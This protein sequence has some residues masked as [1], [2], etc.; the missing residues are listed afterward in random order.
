MDL[1]KL[2][3][4]VVDDD[5]DIREHLLSEF[6][7]LNHIVNSASNFH[8]AK[9]WIQEFGS[10]QNLF[11]IDLQLPDGDGF[12][13]IN[14]IQEVNKDAPI[15]IMTGMINNKILNKAIKHNCYDLIE[16]PFSIK[17]D[18]IPIA[19]KCLNNLFLRKENEYLN[20]QILH[21]SKLAALGELSATIV[22]DVRGPLTM[23]Q[24][25]CEDIKDD[26]KKSNHISE[27]VLNSHLSQISRA[28]HKI[29]K[30][31]D[32]L[33]N[34]SR[35]DILEAE[36]NKSIAELFENSLFLVKQKIRNQ[37][38]KVNVKVEEKLTST[39]IRCFPNKF[40]QVLMNLMSNACDAMK[41]SEK[42]ELLIKAFMKENFLHLSVTDSGSGIPEELKPKIFDSFFTTKP[43]GEGTGLGLSIVKN[44]VGEHSGE[45][46]LDSTVGQ[47]TTFTIK[48]PAS[49]LVL[50]TSVEG[51][52]S[53]SRVA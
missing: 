3:I 20:G 24:L 8:N 36:E 27:E 4:F 17:Y 35:K 32:H 16:K 46:L 50:K 22:H 43:K 7:S 52:S 9:K 37:N 44:I 5:N 26:F 51:S 41:D 11:L 21:N 2:N 49:K 45:L 33:R 12:A 14:N 42:K 31:V 47:G 40:E 1:G 15:I 48:L 38:I 6:R 10:N 13:L 19:N 29:N 28:C 39:E 30:L 53:P 18:I 23:I 34:Y 25:T